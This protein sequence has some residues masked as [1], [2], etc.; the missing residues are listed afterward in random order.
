MESQYTNLRSQQEVDA[1]YKESA[2]TF[3]NVQAATTITKAMMQTGHREF[4]VCQLS[5]FKY[6]F[7]GILRRRKEGAIQ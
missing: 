4:E 7:V 3:T 2:G 5:R 6:V 1:A